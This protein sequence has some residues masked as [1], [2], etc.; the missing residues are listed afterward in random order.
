M[1]FIFHRRPV[2]VTKVDKQELIKR[3]ENKEIDFYY[4][5]DMN[6]KELLSIEDVCELREKYLVNYR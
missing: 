2:L 5:C 1:Q 4:I 3:L 6:K